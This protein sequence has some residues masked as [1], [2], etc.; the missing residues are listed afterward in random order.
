[1]VFGEP[2]GA[3]R[4]PEAWSPLAG[5]VL[6]AT[7]MVLLGLTIPADFDALLRRATEIVIG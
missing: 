5:M 4:R 7:I 6:L 3:G 2:R 1:M